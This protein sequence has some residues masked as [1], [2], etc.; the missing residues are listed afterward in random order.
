MPARPKDPRLLDWPEGVVWKKHKRKNK[1][2]ERETV[3]TPY[4]RVRY[5]GEDGRRHAVWAQVKSP[6][7]AAKV[8][9]KIEAKLAEGSADEFAHARKTFEDLAKFYELHYLKPAVFVNGRKISGA[10][11]Y[12]KVRSFL[13]PMRA[14]FGARRLSGITFNQLNIYRESRLAEPVV[15]RNKAGEITSSRQRA[16][17]SVNREMQLLR[18][19][20]NVAVRERWL[21]SNPFAGGSGLIDVEAENQRERI[22]TPDEEAAALA[23]CDHP[24][25]LHLRPLLLVALD[26]GMRF[27]EIRRMTWR[28]V[29]FERNII[30]ILSTHTKRQRERVV[31][32]SARLR[33]E[34]L[35]WRGQTVAGDGDLVFGIKRDVYSSW[36]TVRRL[37]GIPDVRLHDLRHTNATRLERS[38]RVS[39]KQLGRLLGHTKAQTTY[40]YVNQDMEIVQ[41]AA[42]VLD[43]VGTEVAAKEREARERLP[44]FQPTPPDTRRGAATA[45]DADDG[46]K[47]SP[48]PPAIAGD[49]GRRLAG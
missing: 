16:I 21:K 17:A 7:H 35:H 4:V 22:L 39:L 27:G 38:R 42:S 14:H 2:G 3:E 5:T 47:A 20:L 28:Q 18:A 26:T 34:L 37:A 9:K 45:G 10:R 49:T 19:M 24:R 6:D 29:D 41:E 36:T 12:V 23:A 46:Q 25:R 30:T 8:R 43:A 15:F 31:G 44:N 11:S 13:K 32:M 40:R 33:A 48:R 1:D